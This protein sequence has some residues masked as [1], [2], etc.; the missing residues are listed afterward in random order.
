MTD[1]SSLRNAVT[2]VVLTPED[3][4]FASEGSGFNLAIQQH[5]EVVVGA[6]S[7]ADV[8]A[9]VGFAKQHG[10]PGRVQST[11]HGAHA[12][13]TDG[14]LVST[15]RLDAVTIDADSRIATIGAGARWSAVIAA[16]DPLGLAPITGS[17]PGVGAVGYLLGG[18]LGPLAR[19]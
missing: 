5:P 14:V 12:Q 18:G 10:M 6:A 13:I 8:V 15:K 1:F 2:G 16:A 7:E 19:S 4:D 11:G 9:A 3:A 17:A